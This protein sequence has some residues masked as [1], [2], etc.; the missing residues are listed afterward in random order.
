MR[1]KSTDRTGFVPGSE[2]WLQHQKLLAFRR[3]LKPGQRIAIKGDSQA[4]WLSDYNVRV[5]SEA[6]ILFRTDCIPDPRSKHVFVRID[7]IDGDHNVDV[8]VSKQGIFPID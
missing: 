5:D 6:T 8:F 3:N 2:S 4:I 7:E 1:H